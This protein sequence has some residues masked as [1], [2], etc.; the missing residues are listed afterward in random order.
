MCPPDVSS[1]FVIRFVLP[2]RPPD[3]L[4]RFELAVE[5]ALELA[6]ELSKKLLFGVTRRDHVVTAAARRGLHAVMLHTCSVNEMVEMHECTSCI[7]GLQLSA[8]FIV[9]VEDPIAN[10]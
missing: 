10:R 4:S 3:L 6:F 8:F 7:I 1:R 2:I 5:L 9:N